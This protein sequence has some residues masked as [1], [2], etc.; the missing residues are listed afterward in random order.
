VHE[1]E[2]DTERVWQ[3]RQGLIDDVH[4]IAGE[5][6]AIAEDAAVRFPAEPESET[7]PLPELPP[8]PAPPARKT[9]GPLDDTLPQAV[10]DAE[11]DDESGDHDDDEPPPP[12]P[13]P[14]PASA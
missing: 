9:G 12:P 1:V 10:G 11:D 7:T 13:P 4:R 6:T 8:L 5:L 14:P 3:E 2:A